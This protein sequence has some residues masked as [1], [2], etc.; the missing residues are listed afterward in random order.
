MSV[1]KTKINGS[2][3]EVYGA[4]S[5]AEKNV[6]V[7]WAESDATSDAYI[8]NKPTLGSLAPKNIVEK[9]DLSS[10][11]QSLM[12]GIGSLSNL[13]TTA[14]DNI[15]NAI[16]E[17][18]QSASN[19]KSSIAAAITGEG[20]PAASSETWE[21][22]SSKIHEIRNDWIQ[23]F[24]TNDGNIVPTG[25]YANATYYNVDYGV[26]I[27]YCSNGDI[28]LSMKNGTTTSYENLYFTLA[29]APTGVTLTANAEAQGTSG[30]AGIMHVCI[31]SGVT[32]NINIAVELTD[33]NSSRDY[34]T[35]SITIT[36]A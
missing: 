24:V 20:V 18:F 22:L 2:W 14:K 7:D 6:Q 9:S 4:P 15:V 5:D 35:C 29:S 3:K 36:E 28:M 19:G 21:S 1:L 12:D 17:L 33:I 23:P 27:G 10:G 34:T 16:N 26:K 32:S 11:L 30:T 31:I 13:S 25:K 8:Q